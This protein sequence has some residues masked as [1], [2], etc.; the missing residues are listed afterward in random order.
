MKLTSVMLLGFS[1]TAYATGNAQTINLSMKNT[2]IHQ[3]IKEIAKQSK[4]HYFLDKS[5]LDGIAPL[6]ITI[7]DEKF[8]K[9]M[10]K[11]LKGNNLTYQ[12]VNETIILQEKV[13]TQ[14]E[15]TGSVNGQNGPLAG[16]TIMVENH[17][18]I[19]SKTNDTGRFSIRVPEKSVLIFQYI[20]YTTQRIPL[21]NNHD[22][23]ISMQIQESQLDEVVVI[24]Y[25]KQKR[26]NL[27]GSVDQVSNKEFENRPVTNIGAALQGLIPNLNITNPS[28]NPSQGAKFNVRGI[29]SING[30]EPLVLVDNIPTSSDELAR[31]NPNDFESVSVL[32]DAASAAIYGARGAFGVILITTKSARSEK[33]QVQFGINSQWRNLGKMPE[34]ITN[35][36]TVMQYKHDAA[37]PLYNLFPEAVREYAKKINEDPSLPRVILNPANPEQWAYY[38]ETDWMKEAYHKLAPTYTANLSIGK[39]A[40]NLSYLL[41]SE[42]YKQDGMLKYGN[43]KLDR[44]N[45]RNKVDLKITPWLTIGNNTL[46][47]NRKYNSPV[48][49]DGDFF[50]NVN[51]TSSL[52][53]VRNPDGSWTKAGA[54]LLGFLQ[55]GGRRNRN[56]NEI[57]STFS[58]KSDI[59]KDRWTA[60]ADVTM[61]R[62]YNTTD[63]F[64]KPVSYKTGPNAKE[65]FAGSVTPWASKQDSYTK[66]DVINIYSQYSQDINDHSFSALAGYNQEYRYE[67]YDYTKRTGQYSTDLPSIGLSSGATEVQHNIDDWAVQG[68]FYR[69][70]YGFKNKYLIESNGRFDG[71]S[72]FPKGD[73]WGY[74]PSISAGWVLSEESFFEN[75]KPYVNFIKIRGSY[76][77]LGNQMIYNRSGQLLSYPYIPFM[78]PQTNIPRLIDG[79]K[80]VSLTPP[81]PVAKSLTWERIST[82]N[83]GIDITTLNNRLAANFDLYKRENEGM[84]V[85]GRKLPGVFG[86]QTPSFNA[87]DMETKGWELKIN[88]NDEFNLAGS[89]FKYNMTFGISNSKAFIT[90]YDNPTNSLGD[91]YVGKRVG[92]IWGLLNDGFIQNE[93]ELTA[94]NQTAV[95]TD[96]QAY[97]F[98]VGDIKFKDLNGDKKI[99]FGK[100]TLDDHGDLVILGNSEVQ[101]PYS[102]DLSGSWKGF[103]LRTFIQGVGKRDWYPN[104]Q[105]YFWGIYS[106]PWTNV[107]KQNLN[108]WTPDNRD[109]YFPRVKAYSAEDAM[110]ELS[111]PNDRYLQNAAYLRVKNITLGYTLPEKWLGD[112]GFKTVRFYVTGENLFEKS[113]LKVSLDPESVFN[114]G[115][116]PF[117]R[118]Y[119]FGLNAK[120]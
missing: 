26:I 20:G 56:I 41:S 118:T 37:I 11:A 91:Y 113:N 18:E 76:G 80:P 99:D 109:A 46:L 10:A 102:F 60:N 34:V 93:A 61:R 88:W 58:L 96:D 83:G 115:A 64:D 38:G 45:A 105:I 44:Y 95:G 43:D 110:Q 70:N 27:T 8:N 22:I 42:F 29:T 32:K 23:H 100:R 51:R 112:K 16:V 21:Q 89:P 79:S 7:K 25:G 12:V 52:D 3:V 106:Q 4:M 13:Q 9:A 63:S 36:L 14:I 104:S 65:E 49:M 5:M 39:K 24:G 72:R 17:P 86:S 81:L 31:L 69:L 67:E 40:E 73:R 62:S 111:I 66:Y 15:I 2:R 82:I 6:N 19:K 85:P 107:T 92:E 47:T 108:H 75:A 35:P 71:S 50:W 101:Y 33:V 30:G 120:F 48:F 78:E 84:L 103:D 74:F 54:S 117:Q 119:S 53:V 114:A 68:I 97:K 87:A 77:Q 94:I 55:E 98:Y 57:Q 28:G 116:Y 90:K 59:I 1:L